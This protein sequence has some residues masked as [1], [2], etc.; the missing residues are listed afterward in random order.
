M[1]KIKWDK[2]YSN[3]PNR[4]EVNSKTSYEVLR[5]TEF[6]ADKEQH[7]ETRFAPNQIVLAEKWPVKEKVHTFFHEAIHMLDDTFDIGLSEKQVL[8][9]EKCLPFL[10]KLFRILD[11]R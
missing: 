5:I 9:L 10:L 4:L 1:K 8:K 7:G 3:I 6:P 2:L 11:G